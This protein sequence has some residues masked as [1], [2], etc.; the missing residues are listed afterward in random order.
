[1]LDQILNIAG[2]VPDY[3]LD[4][5]REAQSLDELTAR[6]LTGIGQVIDR[7]K[8][9]RVLVQGDTATAMVGALAAY[10]RQIPVGH[11]E[12]GLRSHDIYNP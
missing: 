7:H 11:I 5:M 10:Y 9:D 4:I 8:P 3:D 1:M 12:A 2:I 6:L